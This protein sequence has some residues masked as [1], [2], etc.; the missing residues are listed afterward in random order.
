MFAR[1]LHLTHM[2]R[3]PMHVVDNN[4]MICVTIPVTRMQLTKLTHRHTEWMG[5]WRENFIL[6]SA[7]RLK[8]APVKCCS[9]SLVSCLVRHYTDTSLV[10][11]QLLHSRV[12]T[13]CNLPLSSVHLLCRCPEI[14]SHLFRV[15]L[16]PA[17]N[18]TRVK[19][20]PLQRLVYLCLRVC[21]VQSYE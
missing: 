10:Y 8:I 7:P 11:S 12:T 18:R 9:S 15:W 4:R 13:H 1:L 16:A 21:Q 2:T 17:K 6:V 14:E 19:S 3:H 5:G 20:I